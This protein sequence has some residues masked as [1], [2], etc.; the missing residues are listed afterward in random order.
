MSPLDEAA[1]VKL[2]KSCTG[3][4][5]GLGW[6]SAQCTQ[7]AEGVLALLA[8][9]NEA[10][11]NSEYL[12]IQRERLRER[13]ESAEQREARLR[14]ALEYVPAEFRR[15]ADRCSRHL[16]ADAEPSCERQAFLYCADRIAVLLQSPK[17]ISHEP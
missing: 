1:L 3:K 13:A 11:K 5:F 7:L 17:D 12:D 10:V 15:M 4:P 2:A 8:E 14:T 6:A 9:R 16:P